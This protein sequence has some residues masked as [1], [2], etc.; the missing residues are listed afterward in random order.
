MFLFGYI[1]CLA[2]FQLITIFSSGVKRSSG[3]K[4]LEKTGYF[5]FPGLS[6]TIT[7]GKDRVAARM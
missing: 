2:K 7:K 5:E 6:L 4:E 3:Y 1:Y